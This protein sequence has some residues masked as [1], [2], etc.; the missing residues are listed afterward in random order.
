MNKIVAVLILVILIA[1]AIKYL[2]NSVQTFQQQDKKQ[3]E[4]SLKFFDDLTV[5]ENGQFY[6][7]EMKL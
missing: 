1:L 3:L 5:D 2:N 6:V 7:N 4:T